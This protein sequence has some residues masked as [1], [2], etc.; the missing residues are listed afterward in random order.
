M[1][2]KV[3]LPKNVYNAMKHLEE[4][5]GI[6]FLFKYEYLIGHYRI[7]NK[8]SGFDLTSITEVVRFVKSSDENRKKY[9]EALVNGYEE[10]LSPEKLLL[11]SYWNKN[12]YL[13]IP[14]NEQEHYAYQEGILHTLALLNLKVKGINK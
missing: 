5:F 3:Q 4:T 7:S 6:D 9:F 14:F 2:N 11:Q 10:K 8:Y 13:S 12:K 1:S